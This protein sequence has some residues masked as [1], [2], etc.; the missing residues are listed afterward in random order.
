M[1]VIIIRKFLTITRNYGLHKYSIPKAPTNQDCEKTEQLS[2]RDVD[3]MKMAQDRASKIRD[4]LKRREEEESM[5]AFEEA[6]K[7]DSTD[8][9]AKRNF[10]LCKIRWWI[11]TAFDD[12]VYLHDEHRVLRQRQ[13][14]EATNDEEP[15][16]RSGPP[17]SSR[18]L[19]PMIITRDQLQSIAI[20][21]GYPSMPTMTIDEFYQSLAQRGLAPTPEQAKEVAAGPKFPSANDIEKEEVAKETHTEKDDPDMLRYLRSKDDYNDEHRRGEGNRYNRS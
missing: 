17:S 8:E 9:E 13:S 10:Y 2:S 3:M 19:K 1:H 4:H 20:G 14:I 5:K 18:P 12:L 6:M 15:H 16:R 7:N 21:R 11:N